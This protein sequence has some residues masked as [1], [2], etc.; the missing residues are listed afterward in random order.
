MIRVRLGE[1]G[2]A[3]HG[4]CGG[5]GGVQQG[6]PA[7]FRPD[8]VRETSQKLLWQDSGQEMKGIRSR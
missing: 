8:P 3:V 4:F 6:G 1:R 2:Q 7:T 5:G